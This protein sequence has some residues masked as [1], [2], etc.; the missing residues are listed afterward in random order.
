MPTLARTVPN[1]PPVSTPLRGKL[2][3]IFVSPG[4]V[5]DEIVASPPK[6]ACWLV[7]TLLVCLTTIVSLLA[8]PV[9][10][11]RAAEVRQLAEAGAIV[12]SDTGK[13][14]SRLLS[15]AAFTVATS[16]V[17]GTFWSAFVLWFMGRIFLKTRFPFLKT[18]EVV[19]VT[20]MILV[21]GTIVTGLLIAATGDAAARPALSIFVGVSNPGTK[22]YSGLEAINLFHLWAATVLAVGLSKLARVS[23]NEAAFWVFGYWVA[24][25]VALIWLA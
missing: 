10:G 17:A 8:A 19:G 3:N 5:F 25:R 21:L 15:A 11:S 18:V 9:S 1:A 22:T 24:L 16:A 7:P 12:S 6:P 2:L 13:L 20:G 4:E 14:S 23:F